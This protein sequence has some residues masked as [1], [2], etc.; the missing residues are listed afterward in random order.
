MKERSLPSGE[1]AQAM[2]AEARKALWVM[3]GF[4]AVI[5]IVQIV[6]WAT[7]YRLSF[8]LGIESRDVS[9]LPEI[10]TAPFLHGSWGHIEGNSGPLFIFGFLAAYRG[11]RR[12]FGV[13]LLII[14]GSGLGVWFVAGANTITVGASG[15]VLGYFGY[16]IVRGLFDRRPIDIVIG[17][18]MA[19]CFAYQFA[20]LLP[21]EEGIS[22]Q[23]H[24]FGF[25]AG[26]IG[27][28]VFR[29]RRRK[30][31]EPAPADPTVTLDP[32]KQP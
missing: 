17:L 31:V 22:W 18:V 30:Q 14:V 11:V 7:G 29:E 9:S 13:T 32:P 27:G 19:L 25:A 21:A 23:G 8:D 15:V 5:W 1:E 3:V 20:A 12:F 24:L 26:V 28:W 6:N 4:L 10:F 2:I 16:I